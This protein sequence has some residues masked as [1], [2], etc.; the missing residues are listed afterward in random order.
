[1]PHPE[2][3]REAVIATAPEPDSGR[4]GA[5]DSPGA[6]VVGAFLRGGRLERLPATRRKRLA[7]LDHL[8]QG[9]EPGIRHTEQEVNTILR[10]FNDDY[11]TLRRSLVDEGFLMRE[12]GQYW[13]TG[14]SV[15]V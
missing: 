13:R 7:V 4:P 3:L 6:A 12:S 9:F 15:D 5:G 14:G 2:A 10:A 8:A 1:M 11:A